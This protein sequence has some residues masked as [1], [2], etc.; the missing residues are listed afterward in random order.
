MIR[1]CILSADG[2]DVCKNTIV[3]K[4]VKVTCSNPECG[5]EIDIQ[6]RSL[7]RYYKRNNTDEYV[8]VHCTTS[9]TGKRQPTKEECQKRSKNAAA[10][11]SRREYR[12]K[13]RVAHKKITSQTEFRTKV[14]QNNKLRWKEKEYQDKMAKLAQDPNY[15]SKLSEKSK[16]NWEDEN[17]RKNVLE[18]KKK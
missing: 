1:F 14:S 11:W 8:C 13:H 16:K 9:R 17:Y 6:K 5:R 7:T 3:A 12:E 10:L 18:R 2:G 15:I 4:R